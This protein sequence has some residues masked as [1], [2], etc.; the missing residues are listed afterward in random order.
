[1]RSIL[2]YTVL[3][4]GL[5]FGIWALLSLTGIHWMFTGILAAVIAMLI[6]VLA[7]SRIRQSVALR[8]EKTVARTAEKSAEKTSDT[9][10]DAEEEDAI[11]DATRAAQAERA[12]GR[13]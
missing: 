10:L 8:L 11:I 4:L 9:D 1:M 7:L 13:S 3:R 5:F 2:L 6:S 12:R